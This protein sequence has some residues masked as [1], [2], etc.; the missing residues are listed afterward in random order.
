[1]SLFI[2]I[3]ICIALDYAHRKKSLNGT[4]LNIVHRDVTPKNVMISYEGEVKLMDFGIAK[5]TSREYKTRTGTIK[6]K[7]MYL[8][9]EQIM[10][11]TLDKR[12]DLFSLGTLFYELLTGTKL[13]KGDSDFSIM[14][15]IQRKDVKED[16]LPNDKIPEDLKPI[17]IKLLEKDREKRYSTAGDIQRDLEKFAHKK[18]IDLSHSNFSSFVKSLNLREKTDRSWVLEPEEINGV[19]TEAFKRDIG[20]ISL[21]GKTIPSPAAGK[22]KLKGKL[23]SRLLLF[24]SFLAINICIVLFIGYFWFGLSFG[25]FSKDDSKSFV[26]AKSTLVTDRIKSFE[27]PEIEKGAAEPDLTKN[28][29]SKPSGVRAEIS[30]ENSIPDEIA[31]TKSMLNKT[32][33]Q[34]QPVIKKTPTPT[35]TPKPKPSFRYV[36]FT[37]PE[38]LKI[39]LRKND[40]IRGSSPYGYTNQ[41]LK[42]RF[43]RKSVYF[44][45]KEPFIFKQLTFNVNE[46]ADT[47]TV[48]VPRVEMGIITIIT[49]PPNCIVK[50]D[51]I[52]I[53]YPPFNKMKINTGKHQFQID[54]KARGYDDKPYIRDIEITQGYNQNLEKQFEK[55]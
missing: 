35:Q 31:A 52:E 15:E 53:G 14:T 55:K 40:I 36:K 23:K 47:L 29:I 44:F 7:I 10:G 6:G 41:R 38:K 18:N 42:F 20:A 1:M 30:S 48:N 5:A 11:K 43:G 37:H 17:L 32:S 21:D 54:C 26:A 8:S 33:I 4:P 49:Q 16:I 24:I 19:S 39:Y 50:V 9:P 22:S 27:P 12:S 51:D 25:R 13:F 2:V 46:G 34:T 3:Q 45:N 28:T